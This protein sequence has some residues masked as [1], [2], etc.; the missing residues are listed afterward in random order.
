MGVRILGHISKLSLGVKLMDL[1]FSLT[2]CFSGFV[3]LRVNW[4]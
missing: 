3:S 4:A 1:C 2:V